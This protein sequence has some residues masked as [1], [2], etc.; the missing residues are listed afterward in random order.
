MNCTFS[1]IYEKL[2]NALLSISTSPFDSRRRSCSSGKSGKNESRACAKFQ[3]RM[4][5]S[6]AGDDISASMAVPEFYTIIDEVSENGIEEGDR[7]VEKLL[8]LSNSS[9]MEDAGSDS[10]PDDAN[11]FM[12]VLKLGFYR[13]AISYLSFT[14]QVSPESDG[15]YIGM[16]TGSDT[17]DLSPQSASP[18]DESLH[19]MKHSQ[20]ELDLSSSHL[21]TIRPE[22]QQYSHTQIL[23]IAIILCPL[24]FVAN[25][26]YKYALLYTSVA[27]STVISNL[28]GG[29]TLLFSWLYGVEKITCRKILGLSI[30]FLGLA[31]LAVSDSNQPTDQSTDSSNSMNYNVR[32]NIFGDIMAVLGAVGYGLYTTILRVKVADDESA[33]MQLLLGYM[34][35][36]NA[37]LFSPAVLLMV[38][39]I[40]TCT[41][42]FKME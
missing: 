4:T 31:A 20:I 42:I 24:W 22:V 34:G 10:E 32:Q 21:Q 35:L 39:K 37:V 2:T 29:F 17:F 18:H 15:S 5:V 38:S 25:C 36:V 27:N 12:S 9:D 14:R 33:S 13:E 41:I 6:L 23:S 26:C 16:T 40:F 28:S 7:S 1:A 11:F 19:V 8:H 3:K 30:C